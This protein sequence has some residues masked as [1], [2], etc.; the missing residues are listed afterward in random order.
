MVASDVGNDI[1]MTLK[2]YTKNSVPIN[3]EMS[4][5][6]I[7][8]RRNFLVGS[9]IWNGEDVDNVILSYPACYFLIYYMRID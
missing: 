9:I 5:N 8:Q 1:D 3:R 7:Y 6:E 2:I 4:E